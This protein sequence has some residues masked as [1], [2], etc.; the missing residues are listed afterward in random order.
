MSRALD[1]LRRGDTPVAPLPPQLATAAGV[2]FVIYAA[3]QPL[4]PGLAA[5]AG[6][7][8]VLLWLAGW[9]SGAVRMTPLGALTFAFFTALLLA[10]ARHVPAADASMAG[11]V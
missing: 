3:A 11:S 5:G 10:I 7:M 9:I 6:V 1:W 2:T 4:S 8:M